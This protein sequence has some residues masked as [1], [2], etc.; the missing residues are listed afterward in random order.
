MFY[1]HGK[2]HSSSNTFYIFIYK[3]W[4]AFLKS[5]NTSFFPDTVMCNYFV[6]QE[7]SCTKKTG[8]YQVKCISRI[9]TEWKLILETL[10]ISHILVS[11][12]R[13]G[14]YRIIIISK[15]RW[16][17]KIVI[18]MWQ[19]WL[20]LI[21]LTS[22]EIATVMTQHLSSKNFFA[23]MRWNAQNLQILAAHAISFFAKFRKQNRWIYKG[24][25]Y[26]A[27]TSLVRT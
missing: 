1:H 26:Y 21:K 16:T 9:S 18:L 3:S 25:L 19:T 23:L 14:K 11:C 2:T 22:C 17:S 8:I 7:K 12:G 24:N 15:G 5:Y 20:V 6:T 10:A 13:M 4:H 27:K